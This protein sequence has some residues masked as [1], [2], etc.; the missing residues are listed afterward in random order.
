MLLARL[1]MTV[2]MLPP[3]VVNTPTTANAIKA[4]LPRIPKVPDLSRPE[5][6]S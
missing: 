6:N 2:L 3:R 5:E 4:G 1:V